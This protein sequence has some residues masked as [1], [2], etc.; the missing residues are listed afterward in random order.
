MTERTIYVDKISKLAFRDALRQLCDRGVHV[1]KRNIIY[2]P[3][4]QKFGK[5]KRENR[6]RPQDFGE[7]TK[8][9]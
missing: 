8:P 4:R 2:I 9:E 7:F 3:E 1:R 6:T 5:G